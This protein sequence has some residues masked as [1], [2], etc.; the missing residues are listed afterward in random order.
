MTVTPCSAQ[1][2]CGQ[3]L[4]DRAWAL[5]RLWMPEPVRTP[6]TSGPRDRIG[7]EVRQALGDPPA[8]VEPRVE[9]RDLQAACSITGEEA[10]EDLRGLLPGNA[11]RVAV[12]HGRHQGI[13]EN[14]DV[15]MHPESFKF[16]LGYGGQR[17][18]KNTAG[19]CLPDL[20]EVNDGDGGAPDVLAE[21][22]V[23]IVKDPVADEGD[24]LVPD[25]RPQP[26]EVGEQVRTASR[27]HR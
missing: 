21:E 27:C 10:A 14:I 11:A 15:E 4:A 23:V 6:V 20:R 13:I 17:P 25:Q 16:R 26:I 8:G 7:D 1:R 12:V 2:L 19:A 9:D 5:C 24:V 3:G 22:M 18:F